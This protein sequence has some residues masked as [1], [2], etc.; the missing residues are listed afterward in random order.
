MT[1][2]IRRDNIQGGSKQRFSAFLAFSGGVLCVYP[3]VRGTHYVSIPV[4]GATLVIAGY[5]W[6]SYSS[7][8][9]TLPKLEALEKDSTKMNEEITSYQIKIDLAKMRAEL[10]GEL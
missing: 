7:L 6:W 1:Q 10:R 2:D 4:C 3:V 8:S 9:K 5:S